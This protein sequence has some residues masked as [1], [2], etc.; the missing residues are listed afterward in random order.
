[1]K[2]LLA[3]ILA[4]TLV[5]AFAS[6]G[7]TTNANSVADVSSEASTKLVM[8]TNAAFPPYEYVDGDK[9]VGI[10][11]EIAEAIA[12]KLGLELEIQDVD[13]DTILGLVE[14]NKV[15]IGMSG[16][17]VTEDRL[18]SVNFSTTYATAVQVVLV[19]EGGKVASIEDLD[20]EDIMIGVQQGTT[21]DI[22]ACDDYGIEKVTQYKAYGDAVA[23]LSAGKID[24]L[25]LDS[26]PG[27]AFAAANEGLY[28]LET[29]YADE[30]Y[31]ICINKANT[32]LLE[33]INTALGELIADGTVAQITNKYI[34]ADEQ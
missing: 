33:K 14:T 10:D 34:P 24:A 23:S 22:Y 27:K 26:E 28:V 18:K 8:A 11:V 29:A 13:F 1:M 2:K 17:T 6:C 3:V 9:Y 16:M 20:K 4:L 15:D 21:G 12:A 7:D 5:L 30:E 19:K 32:E 31:A 25:I